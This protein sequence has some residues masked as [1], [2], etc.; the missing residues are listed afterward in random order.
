MI[1]ALRKKST[2]RVILIGIA[3][4]ITLC[5]VL[6]GVPMGLSE[7][8]TDAVAGWLGSQKIL[9]GHFLKNYKA[10]RTEL[11]FSLGL[12]ESELSRRL[13]MEQLTW[14]RIVLLEAAQKSNIRVPDQEIVEWI[15]NVPVFSSEGRFNESFYQVFVE[16]RLRITPREFEEN[17]RDFLT[18]Q[19]LR[20]KVTQ[21]GPIPEEK[22]KEL[23]RKRFSPRDLRYVI[24]P[25][26]DPGTLITITQ[27]EIDDLFGSMK[28]RLRSPESFRVRYIQ[29]DK[30]ASQNTDEIRSDILEHGVERS[31]DYG[32][33]PQETDPFSLDEPI[34]GIGF[35]Q[36]LQDA[37]SR[38]RKEGDL[39]PWTEFQ[40]QLFLLELVERTPSRALTPEAARPEL[41]KILRAQKTDRALYEHTLRVREEM[42][43]EGLLEVQKRRALSLYEVKNYRRGEYLEK[44]GEMKTFDRDISELK[45]GEISMPVPTEKVYTLIQVTSIH[46]LT[47]WSALEKENQRIRSEL[48]DQ[49]RF[50][51]YRSFLAEE[52]SELRVNTETM[53]AL[54]PQKYEDR[55]GPMT[56]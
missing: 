39:T 40:D 47:D 2:Q 35:S 6:W 46:G 29:L 28:G 4:V 51:K 13:D 11:L 48:Q 33:T 26:A 14:E 8:K 18:I 50:A 36:D 30:N 10:L 16:R 24:I 21:T 19:K 37:V 32:L 55:E 38:L 3:T 44:V 45:E 31:G 5:F 52:T 25:Q 41:E 1:K 9:T 54:F 53:K 7:R 17:I 42:L 20:Y 43:L 15:Q 27:D 12:G 22:V 23:F 49:A 34:P 56:F